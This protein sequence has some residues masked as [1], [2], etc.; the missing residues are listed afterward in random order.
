MF[1]K[2]GVFKNFAIFTGKHLYQSLFLTDVLQ[3]VYTTRYL[4]LS[5]IC[6]GFLLKK[7][8][9]YVDCNKCVL[10]LLNQQTRLPYTVQ[11]CVI[12]GKLCCFYLCLLN[13]LTCKNQLTIFQDK[14]TLHSEP[15]CQYID[16][17]NFYVPFRVAC[18]AIVD[19]RHKLNELLFH[20]VI[21]RRL[22]DATLNALHYTNLVEF[23]IMKLL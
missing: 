17:F 14:A 6:P 16:S 13:I 19:F 5:G 12:E 3:L 8:W 11:T 4:F 18:Q 15:L 20:Q 23:I 22:R 2:I 7:L 21:V 10:I 1:F 9:G